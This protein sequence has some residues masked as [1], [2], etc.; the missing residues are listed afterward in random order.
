[1]SMDFYPEDCTEV[2]RCGQAVPLQYSFWWVVKRHKGQYYAALQRE[3]W[4]VG[5]RWFQ[6]FAAPVKFIDSVMLLSTHPKFDP[7]MGSYAASP[8]YSSTNSHVSNPRR[9]DPFE[10]PS[11]ESVEVSSAPSANGNI[12]M[13]SP[14]RFRPR[15]V[16][17]EKSQND[18]EARVAKIAKS[19][20]HVGF[21]IE[22]STKSKL[23]A[24]SVSIQFKIIKC[25][26]LSE[27]EKEERLRKLLDRASSLDP[28]VVHYG[29]VWR[30]VGRATRVR[31]RKG[32]RETTR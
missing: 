17:R 21:D 19:M 6:K 8:G 20:D 29:R 5:K 4:D 11:G 32:M 15:G 10:L 18:Y 7:S 1:M 9:S 3:K 31:T 28:G 22:N 24:S 30:A 14:S 16:K 2:S 27:A 25:L 23:V 12:P 13:T 26:S